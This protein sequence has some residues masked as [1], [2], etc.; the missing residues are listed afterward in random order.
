MVKSR[1][2]AELFQSPAFQFHFQRHAAARLARLQFRPGTFYSTVKPYVPVLAMLS[3]WVAVMQDSYSWSSLLKES[4]SV[5]HL[6]M[7]IA[8]VLLWNLVCVR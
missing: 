5:W 6:G 1:S 2:L 8:L 3:A 7:G 4:I